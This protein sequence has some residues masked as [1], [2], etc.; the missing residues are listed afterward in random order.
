M[1]VRF[2]Q[3]VQA[4]PRP[5]ELTGLDRGLLLLA[6]AGERQQIAAAARF[7]TELGGA[8]ILLGATGFGAGLLLYRLLA[9]RIG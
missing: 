1:P 9:N 8:A 6:Y 7:V 2:G 4:L 5:A 3:E